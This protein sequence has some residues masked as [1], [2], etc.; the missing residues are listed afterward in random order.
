[1]KEILVPARAGKYAVGAFEFWSFDSAQAVVSAAEAAG[2]PVIL[3]A[4]LLESHYAGGLDI[5]SLIARR[6]AE[7]ARIPIALHLDHAETIGL[8]Q[9]AIDTGF[10]S[11]M[12]DTS[13]LPFE[14]NIATT[15]QVVAM[16][17]PKGVTVEAEL[18]RLATAEGG[19]A[20]AEE[21]QTDPEEARLFVERTGIDA[22]AVAIGTAHGAYRFPPRINIPRLKEI[23][24]AVAIPLVLHGGSG[25]PAPAVAEA[26]KNGIAKVNICTDLIT[27]YGVRAVE[28]SGTPDFKYSVA[29]YFQ[30]TKNAARELASQK[31]RQFA[32]AG[33]GT[34]AV[35]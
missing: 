29:S 28:L 11:V 16:A 17:K 21:A 13:S 12:I 18:G 6:V 9:E 32:G 5:L 31:I 27:A 22:L 24:A 19:A 23:A 14:E 7:K 10:T 33:G 26:I 34:L 35:G 3:Q 4:G 30:E 15:M 25:T 8:V 1:M 2:M 20:A